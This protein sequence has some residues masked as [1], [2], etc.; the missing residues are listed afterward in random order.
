IQRL[1]DFLATR[2]KVSWS[3][4]PLTN[5]ATR[6]AASHPVSLAEMVWLLPKDR[7]LKPTGVTGASVADGGAYWLVKAK[8]VT[9]LQF[10]TKPNPA[11]VPS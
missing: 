9:S 3:Q 7:Y 6:V 10:D 8:A 11:Y 2:N 4:T 5:G 1:A